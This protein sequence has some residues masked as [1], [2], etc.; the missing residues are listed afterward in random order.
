MAQQLE[1]LMIP[2]G[3]GDAPASPQDTKGAKCGVQD[4]DYRG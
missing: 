4:S 3:L 2:D 1:A